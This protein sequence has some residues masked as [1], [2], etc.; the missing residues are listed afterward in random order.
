MVV[1]RPTLQRP[2]LGEHMKGEND[3][4]YEHEMGVME[5]MC[6][7]F[8]LARDENDFGRQLLYC[9]AILGQCAVIYKLSPPAG[10][11]NPKDLFD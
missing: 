4:A 2:I 3:P 10:I 5:N 1:S 8:I 9:G 11:M 6:R 7:E